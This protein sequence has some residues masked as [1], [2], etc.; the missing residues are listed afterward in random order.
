[1]TDKK[2]TVKEAKEFMNKA[3]ECYKAQTSFIQEKEHILFRPIEFNGKTKKF[4]IVRKDNQD[5]IL[6]EI[7]WRTGWRRYVLSCGWGDVDFD[8]SCLKLITA[9]IEDLMSKNDKKNNT[10]AS[11]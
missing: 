7:K 8:L 11:R 6:A 2:L 1:M 4:A 5:D 9:F 3:N 10:K